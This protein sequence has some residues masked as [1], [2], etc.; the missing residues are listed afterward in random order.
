MQKSYPRVSP[1]VGHDLLGLHSRG[2]RS[3]F[4]LRCW[5]TWLGDVGEEKLMTAEV[6]TGSPKEISRPLERCARGQNGRGFRQGFLG[7]VPLYPAVMNVPGWTATVAR[8]HGEAREG[9]SIASACRTCP[10]WGGGP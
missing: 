1:P 4:V 3:S 2:R 6:I 5:E 10:T 7:R 9:R 8:P